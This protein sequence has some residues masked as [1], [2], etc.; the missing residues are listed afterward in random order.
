MAV[1]YISTFGGLNRKWIPV[2]AKNV[3]V[4]WDEIDETFKEIEFK[5]TTEIMTEILW[6]RPL[7]AQYFFDVK[8]ISSKWS[9]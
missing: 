1:D 5:E 8:Q 3:V 9:P 4:P 2:W 7:V 6:R